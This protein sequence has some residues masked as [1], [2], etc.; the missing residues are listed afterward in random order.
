MN[1]S[2]KIA[3][4]RKEK[5]LSQ[6]ALAEKL[7][8]SRQS[9]SKWESGA[10]LPD[11]DKIIAAIEEQ[12]YLFAES[13]DGEPY[14][15][16]RHLGCYSPVIHL[17]QTDGTAS[18]HLPFTSKYNESGIINGEAVLRA[19]HDSYTQKEEA[20]LP[21]KCKKIYLTLEIFAGTG[22]RNADILEKLRTSVAYWRQFIPHDGINLSSCINTI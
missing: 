5:G 15:W 4:L 13:Q 20:G 12:T 1:I 3:I 9:V 16:L 21:P 7:G 18:A 6:E 22:E 10:A 14:S 11:T 8:V 19:I 2:D 17:Q